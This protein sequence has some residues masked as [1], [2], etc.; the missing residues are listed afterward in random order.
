MAKYDKEFERLSKIE[1][2]DADYVRKRIQSLKKNYHK[3]LCYHCDKPIHPEDADEVV[4]SYTSRESEIFLCN[5]CAVKVFGGV[6]HRK[7]GK[8]KGRTAKSD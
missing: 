6:T 8:K 1:L 4:Y 7:G 3:V 2:V 5:K